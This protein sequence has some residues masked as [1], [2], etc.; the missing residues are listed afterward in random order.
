MCTA[1]ASEIMYASALDV[2]FKITDKT[3]LPTCT[4]MLASLFQ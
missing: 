3:D 4:P 1:R 2:F